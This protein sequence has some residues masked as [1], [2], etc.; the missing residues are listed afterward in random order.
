VSYTNVCWWCVLKGCVCRY[1]VRRRRANWWMSFS[2]NSSRSM[3]DSSSRCWV[4][5]CVRE[6]ESV[7]VCARARLSLSLSLSLSALVE[8]TKFAVVNLRTTLQSHKR[9]TKLINFS[10]VNLCATI[11][12]R[13]SH[14]MSTKLIFKFIFL[15]FLLL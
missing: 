4:C 12:F 13:L 7:C 1:V 8:E 3:T 2:P 10:L 14:F 15:F 6:R 11:Q 9:K 5:V